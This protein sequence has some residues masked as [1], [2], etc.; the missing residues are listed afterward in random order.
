MKRRRRR[1]KFGN[2]RE[3][4][5]KLEQE[6]LMSKRPEKARRTRKKT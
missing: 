4:K 2:K 3:V 1:K 6:K 5:E